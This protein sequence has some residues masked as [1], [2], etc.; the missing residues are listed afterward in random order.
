MTPGDLRKRVERLEA[1]APAGDAGD[2]ELEAKFAAMTD[3][4]L[5]AALAERLELAAADPELQARWARMDA[6]TADQL[7]DYLAWCRIPPAQRGEFKW[8]EN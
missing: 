4:E 8:P 5:D 2:P 3:A 6:L 7:D 1:A